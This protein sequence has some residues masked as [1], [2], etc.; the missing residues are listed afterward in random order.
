MVKNESFFKSQTKR[1]MLK[2]KGLLRPRGIKR[3][4]MT[5][6]SLEEIRFHY[7]GNLPVFTKTF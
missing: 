3:H 2:L 6:K 1:E 5:Q 4:V 7:Y